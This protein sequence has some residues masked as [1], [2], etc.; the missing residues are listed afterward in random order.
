M[1]QPY[2]LILRFIVIGLLLLV[3]TYQIGEHIINAIFPLYEWMIRQFD[4]RF[5][6]II[7][8]IITQHGEQ[9]LLLQV[10]LSQSIIV[11][12]EIIEL[13]YP[14]LSAVTMPL[15]NVL[16]PIVLIFTIVLAWPIELNHHVMRI[17][18]VRIVLALPLCVFI[19]LLD[20]PTQLT[21]MV[22]ESLN[23]LL[24]LSISSDLPYFTFWSDFL[25]GGGLI[26][27]SITSGLLVV[28]FVDLI[29]K[30]VKPG[31][32]NAN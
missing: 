13:N 25:N 30:F 27:L 26:A 15:G 3:V 31:F 8:T 29:P 17:Y 9:F 16:L 2:T 12:T 11:G 21:K 7:F 18:V 24:N 19:M 4:Y 5:D 6:T 32:L 22:W 20:I 23:K 1:R 14:I 28:A 10:M